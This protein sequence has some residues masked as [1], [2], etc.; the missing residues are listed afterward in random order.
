MK[1]AFVIMLVIINLFLVSGCARGEQPGSVFGDENRFILIDE[2]HH[3]IGNRDI[4]IYAD[5]DTGV[6]YMF[7]RAGY[8]AGLSPLYNSDGT[9]MIYDKCR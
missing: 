4:Y 3:D 1:K 8:E 5:V 7:V 2:N 9:L 6:M